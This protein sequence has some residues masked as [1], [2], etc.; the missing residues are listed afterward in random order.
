MKY[1][2]SFLKIYLKRENSFTRNRTSCFELFPP[3]TSSA[4]V[5]Y[6]LGDV[7]VCLCTSSKLVQTHLV[8]GR[9]WNFRACVNDVG[10]RRRRRHVGSILRYVHQCGAQSNVILSFA[11]RR[12]Y[13]YA[14]LFV[15]VNIG[16]KVF[17]WEGR[18]DRDA[19]RVKRRKNGLLPRCES[20][21][22]NDFLTT[23]AN[24]QMN[25]SRDVQ[26][27]RGKREERI[28]IPHKK[29]NAISVILLARRIRDLVCVSSY[30]FVVSVSMITC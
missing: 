12:K 11:S 13:Q 30:A 29:T 20:A 6:N 7:H 15:T 26:K 22:G 3:V 14:R 9:G 25:D 16:F 28:Q 24:W 8:D 4:I 10:R 21:T 17:P 19:F 23:P 2:L 1:V 5:S 27:K 18:R